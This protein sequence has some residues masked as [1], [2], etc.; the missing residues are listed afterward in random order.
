MRWKLILGACVAAASGL[1]AAL[2]AGTA[3][4]VDVP[5]YCCT[6]QK[7]CEEDHGGGVITG[8]LPRYPDRPYCDD[9]GVHPASEGVGRTCIA[10]PLPNLGTICVSSQDCTDPAHPAC[11]DQ[12]CQGC[13]AGA[14]C[15]AAAP[16][17]SVAHVCSACTQEAD[18]ASYV[19]M[20]HCG[21]SG[22]CVACRNEAD[23]ADSAAPVCDPGTA[24]CRACQADAECGSEI[25]DEGAG[26]CVPETEIVYVNGSTGVLSGQ[27]T[28]ATPCKT[29]QLGV[30]AVTGS[31]PRV[32]VA[33]GTYTDKVSVSGKMLQILAYG[34]E[35]SP[36]AGPGIEVKGASTVTIEGIHVKNVGGGANGDGVR[37]AIDGTDSPS[38]TLV[39]VVVEGSQGKGVSA[40]QCGIS[41]ARSVIALN[42]GGGINL[43][44][45]DTSLVN[46]FI[47]KNGNGASLLGG[48]FLNGAGSS[49]EITFEFNTVVGNDAVD[50]VVSGVQC[51]AVGGIV[52]KN[53]IVYGNDVVG[54]NQVSGNCAWAFSDI[55][56]QAQAG[57]GNINIAPVFESPTSNDY[58][59][60]SGSPGIDAADPAATVNIDI[61]GDARPAGGRSDMGAD[62]V[63]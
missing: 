36:L 37:C 25:C 41:V 19:S 16:V 32:H 54:V 39:N 2:V 4:H 35:L 38:L 10:D 44:S 3:C 59:L 60:K 22:A 14:D 20:P 8:C 58:H 28:K 11:I 45:S 52:A 13:G 24:T 9:D 46:N 27:C 47:A 62:E 26:T 49:G 50:G 5:Y 30:D 18:C 51:S 33:P 12:H 1:S 61:D 21:A 17:C 29:I 57:Q 6:T 63:Q 40:T 55:G 56:P 34:V 23:C 15:T 42:A 7:S 48:V 43:N 53:S 31:R